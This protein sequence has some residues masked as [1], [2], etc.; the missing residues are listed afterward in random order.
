MHARD[1]VKEVCVWL[2]RGAH[3]EYMRDAGPGV[4]I[5]GRNGLCIRCVRAVRVRRTVTTTRRPSREGICVW[6]YWEREREARY[7]GLRS[8]FALAAVGR[9]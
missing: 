1:Y 3:K 2:L 6:D 4:Y 9:N 7:R 8:D 5:H